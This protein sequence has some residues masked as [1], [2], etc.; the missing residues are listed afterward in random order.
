[1]LKHRKT[2]FQVFGAVHV[3]WNTNSQSLEM[4]YNMH[5]VSII[6][7]IEGMCCTCAPVLDELDHERVCRV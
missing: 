3:L 1:M 4:N 5:T 2:K 7:E 6:L